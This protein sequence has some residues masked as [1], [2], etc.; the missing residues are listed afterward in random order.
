MKYTANETPL[1]K[2]GNVELER[3]E[4]GFAE[5]QHWF[6][7][8]TNETD[9]FWVSIPDADMDNMEAIAAHIEKEKARLMQAPATII[10]LVREN[11]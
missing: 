6:A 9:D 2:F 8:V 11:S 1:T 10:I 3:F 5:T 4:Q 7:H